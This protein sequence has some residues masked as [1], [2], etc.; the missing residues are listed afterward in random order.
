MDDGSDLGVGS[1]SVDDVEN[2]VCCEYRQ[3]HVRQKERQHTKWGDAPSQDAMT[4]E[5]EGN[6][7][8][9]QR[10]HQST[11]PPATL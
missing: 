5:L 9:A 7:G 4:D 1:S 3:H 8:V 6:D 2:T 11:Q 10:V